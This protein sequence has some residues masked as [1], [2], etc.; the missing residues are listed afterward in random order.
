ME[1]LI[2]RPLENALQGANGV[3][4]VRSES[5]QGLSVITVSFAEGSDPFRA[6]QVVAESLAEAAS[7]LPAG[8]APP[9]LSPLT[10][11]TMDLLKIGFLSDTLSPLE[12]RDLVEWTVRP[13]LLAVP[14]LRGPRSSVAR[15]GAS[16][17]GCARSR[18]SP[19]T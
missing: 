8:V 9:K 11:S 17:S 7:A 19:A 12:L 3:S 16:R 14:G 1:Q 2:T 18:C 15:C 4:G 10:S 6:R 13:R 5:I